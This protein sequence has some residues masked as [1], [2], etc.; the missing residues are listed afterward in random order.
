MINPEDI[1]KIVDNDP[2]LKEL[3]NELIDG[4]K[5]KEED[6]RQSVG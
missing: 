6:G 1:E 3:K 2:N 4:G 5:E